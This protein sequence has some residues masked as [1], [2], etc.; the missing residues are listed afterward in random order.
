MFFRVFK[1]FGL[2]LFHSDIANGV[3]I[4][5]HALMQFELLFV[6]KVEG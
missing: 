6:L 4:V 2:D 5:R 1:V 3:E